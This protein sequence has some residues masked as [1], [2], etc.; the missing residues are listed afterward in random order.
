MLKD[1]V[2]E[3][4]LQF[5]RCRLQGIDVTTIKDVTPIP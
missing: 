3:E 2:Q 5:A 4:K 1:L